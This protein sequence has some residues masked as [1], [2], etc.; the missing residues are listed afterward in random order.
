MKK[1]TF[2]SAALNAEIRTA[3]LELDGL[4]MRDYP[5]FCDAFFCYGERA[6]GTPL[7]NEQLECLTESE[8]ERL[9]ELAHE[10]MQFM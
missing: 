1:H 4:D 3:S 7:T 5:D 9:N 6:D 2:F 10:E 8:G